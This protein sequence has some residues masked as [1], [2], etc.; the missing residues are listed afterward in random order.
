[1]HRVH[2]EGKLSRL[3]AS[4][5]EG[6]RVEAIK[7]PRQP[8]GETG[9]AWVAQ[10]SSLDQVGKPAIIPSHASRPTRSEGV[11]ADAGMLAAGRSALHR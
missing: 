11:T 10:T 2:Q 1:M 4:V 5:E 8:S 3:N 9:P 7:Q 6:R